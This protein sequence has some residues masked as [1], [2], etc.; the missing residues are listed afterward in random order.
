MD[1]C[2]IN[3]LPPGTG[4]N[5]AGGVQQPHVQVPQGHR[6]GQGHALGGR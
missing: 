5:A 6:W 4:V 2:R 3:F 1:V